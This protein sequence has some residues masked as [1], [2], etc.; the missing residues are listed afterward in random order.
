MR[1]SNESDEQPNKPVLKNSARS[2][3][4]IGQNTRGHF[5]DPEGK[6]HHVKVKHIRLD[7]FLEVEE[8]TGKQFSI[9]FTRFTPMSQIPSK[10]RKTQ[11]DYVAPIWGQAIEAYP[12]P[13]EFDP[14]PLSADTYARK[15]REARQAKQKFGYQNP[16]INEEKWRHYATDI[17]IS[18]KSDG[19]VCLGPN[20]L[21]A[22]AK[23]ITTL[24]RADEVVVE[25]LSLQDLENLCLLIERN[26]FHPKPVFVVTGLN[27]ETI[28]SL[29]ERYDVAFTP[30]NDQAGKWQ[31]I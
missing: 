14:A 16:A 6:V 9:Y 18:V 20:Q 31:L 27:D 8:P 21:T 29:E 15:L 10:F 4:K 25:F 17:A 23:Q 11:F 28:A 7:K 5:T 19:K 1:D 30:V 12:V 3:P 13:V 24:T 2:C 26:I 22:P